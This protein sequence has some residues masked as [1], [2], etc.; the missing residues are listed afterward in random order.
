LELCLRCLY[1]PSDLLVAN[2]RIRCGAAPI[3]IT[4]ASDT[5]ST[6]TSTTDKGNEYD[7]GYSE[8]D[9]ALHHTH[10]LATSRT[11]TPTLV[12]PLVATVATAGRCLSFR[13]NV[14]FH[15][16]SRDDTALFSPLFL[17]TSS[18]HNSIVSL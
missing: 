4:N 13:A 1:R 5:A 2:G 18:L 17:G 8:S 12:A 11:F 14:H 10:L 3:V 15:E 6:A 9:V 7:E 16:V